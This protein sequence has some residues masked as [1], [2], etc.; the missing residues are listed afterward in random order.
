MFVATATSRL[1]LE[2]FL[3]QGLSCQVSSD[4][5]RSACLMAAANSGRWN[6]SSRIQGGMA[7]GCSV[8]L[9]DALHPNINKAEMNR[10]TR[11]MPNDQAQPQPSGDVNELRA[12]G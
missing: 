5:S 6:A 11:M 9:C 4:K 12:S 3:C 7:T 2:K 1:S 8:C 10:R